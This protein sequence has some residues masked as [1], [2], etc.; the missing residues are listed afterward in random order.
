M[1]RHIVYQGGVAEGLRDDF[2]YDLEIGHRVHC[3]GDV[4]VIRQLGVASYTGE[5]SFPLL[6]QQEDY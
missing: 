2:P 5:Q 3:S 4:Y 1:G 6:R